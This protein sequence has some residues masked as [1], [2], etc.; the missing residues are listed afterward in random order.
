MNGF[1]P[2]L[3]IALIIFSEL[4]R[5]FTGVGWGDEAKKGRGIRLYIILFH[6][7]L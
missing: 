2:E 6:Y 7:Q 4:K 3:S 1:L 5:I